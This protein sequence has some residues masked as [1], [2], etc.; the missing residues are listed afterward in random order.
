MIDGVYNSRLYL[1]SRTRLFIYM[2]KMMI[3]NIIV[4][5]NIAI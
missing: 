1:C 4:E 3:L 2:Q 5:Q